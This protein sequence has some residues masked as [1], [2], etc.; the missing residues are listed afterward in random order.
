MNAWSLLKSR[1]VLAASLVLVVAGALALLYFCVV[2][3]VQ[4][5]ALYQTRSWATPGSL[6]L[7][8]GLAGLAAAAMGTWGV[9][10]QKAALREAKQREE[11][12]LRRVRDYRRD[13][14]GVDTLDGRREPYIGRDADRRVA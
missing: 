13:S 5:A 4:V 3:A 8:S 7:L 10:R 12:R 1:I 2:L 11:D 9:F 14:V 6:A